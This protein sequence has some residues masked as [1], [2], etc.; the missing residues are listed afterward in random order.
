MKTVLTFGSFDHLHPGHIYY[1]TEA[2]SFGDKLVVIVARDKTI[3]E[4]KHQKP[5][6]NEKERLSHVKA[7]GMVDEAYLGSEGDKYDIVEKIKPDIICL[8]YDQTA[9]T[10]ELKG[11]LEKRNLKA[12]IIRLRAFHP[13]KYKSSKL[14]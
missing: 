2:K 11:E 14:K 4:V 9:F 1:L 10:G 8:G 12:H 13:E 7:L 5:K 6:Y 3:E